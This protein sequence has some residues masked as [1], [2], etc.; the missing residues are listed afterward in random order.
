MR[1][2][3]LLVGLAALNGAAASAQDAEAGAKVWKKCA[4][5]H[6]VGEG[7]KNRVGPHLNEV[8]ERGAGHLEGFKFSKAMKAAGDSGLV[9]NA[10]TLDAF[11]ENP[12]KYM[13]G[14]KM[15]FA[16]LK[17]PKDRANLIAW[18][19]AHALHAEQAAEIT[20]SEDVLAIVGDAE[21][22]EYLSGDCTTCH[23]LD[24][25]DDG[26]PNITGWPERAFVTA[27]HAYKQKAREHPVMQMMAGRL[28]DEE[29]AGLAAYFATLS[30]D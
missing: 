23:R 10:E 9:W 22:G 13:P 18:L 19:D 3:I 14:T 17:K 21:Y 2:V 4:A 16:G 27:M 26:I 20:L 12:R 6:Q 5:C 24:G 29:I 8:F 7:A 30:T 11:L 15:S 25:S 28:S 1:A